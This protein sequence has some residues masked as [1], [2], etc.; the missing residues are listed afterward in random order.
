MLFY[1]ECICE[2]VF[3]PLYM[4]DFSNKTHREIP[5]VFLLWHSSL[6]DQTNTSSHYNMSV[7]DKLSFHHVVFP[8]IQC[9]YYNNKFHIMST[10][11]FLTSLQF[12]LLITHQMILL[13][14]NSTKSLNTCIYA[15]N[16]KHCWSTIFRIDAL[17]RILFKY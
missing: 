16:K 12:P 1:I 15:H 10:I 3:L 13:H 9:M 5:I 8:H 6:A 17:V 4:F 11:N 14:E 7:Q 2:S